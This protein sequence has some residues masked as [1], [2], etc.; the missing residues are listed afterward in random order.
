MPDNAPDQ[1]ES[2][3]ETTPKLVITIGLGRTFDLTDL[4]AQILTAYNDGMAYGADVQH[5]TFRGV[6]TRED[7]VALVFTAER[8]AAPEEAPTEAEVAAYF[9][10]CDGCEDSSPHDT[11]LTAAGRKHYLGEGV[12]D[13]PDE[14]GIKGLLRSHSVEVNEVSIATPYEPNSEQTTAPGTQFDLLDSDE[15]GMEPGPDDVRDG[16]DF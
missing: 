3:V 5:V 11:H 4:A 15:T 13:R 2:P 14:T 12:I 9:E 8:I 1:T 16:R 7:H 6:D 10:P